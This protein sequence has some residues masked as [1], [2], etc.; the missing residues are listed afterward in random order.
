MNIFYVTGS[1][2]K[3]KEAE[4]Y[5]NILK[6][7]FSAEIS[8]RITEKGLQEILDPD[9]DRVVRAKTL[10][11]YKYLALPCIVEHSGLFMKALPGL[12]GGL[13]QLIW[14]AVGDRMCDFLRPQDSREATARSIIGYCD[15]RRVRLYHGET[16]GQVAERA[17]GD[18]KFNWDPIF[19][20]DGSD[21][22]YGE[23]GLEKKRAT[24]PAFK[25]W[26]EFLTTEFPPGRPPVA[27]ST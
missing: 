8:I 10:E 2:F 17:R 14:Y 11:A 13:G 26:K 1:S 23:M 18:Y 24:S 12:P 9:M 15:G 6:G 5:Q 19:I 16:S 21:Q 22:T 20:P 4:D 25:A 27:S 3:P 7:Q